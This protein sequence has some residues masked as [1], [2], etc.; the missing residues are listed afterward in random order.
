MTK[1]VSFVS[2]DTKITDVAEI[3]FK[4]RF[5]GLPV[6]DNDKIVGIITETDFFTKDAANLYLPSYISFLKE[7]KI[8]DDFGSV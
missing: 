6:L 1:N 3:M 8:A 5:H 7:N 4:N 2:P